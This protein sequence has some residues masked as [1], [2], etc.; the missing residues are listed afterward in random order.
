VEV[1][2]PSKIDS[3]AV[4]RASRSRSKKLLDAGVEFYEYK[5][6]LYHCKIMIVDDVW[7]TVGSVNF[8]EKSFHANDEANLNVLNKDFAAALSKTLDEDKSKSHRLT[9]GDFK[10]QSLFTKIANCFFGLFHADL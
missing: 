3:F 4:H 7:A 9:K 10:R 6:T 8:D 2:I 5:P 1:I